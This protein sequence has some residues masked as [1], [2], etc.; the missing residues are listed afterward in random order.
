MKKRTTVFG[1]GLIIVTGIL[2]VFLLMK[3][4]ETNSSLDF[5]L[6][7]IVEVVLVVEIVVLGNLSDR[8]WF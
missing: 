6:M 5:V 1:C 8:V 7:A 3:C 2:L 4:F